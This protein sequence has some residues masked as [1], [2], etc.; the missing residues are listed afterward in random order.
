MNDEEIER[1]LAKWG[2]QLLQ[3]GVRKYGRPGKDPR[4]RR[5]APLDGNSVRKG[6]RAIVRRFPEVMVKVT[7]G[8]R[9]MGA[10]KAHM[11]YI[12]RR[13]ELALE[14]EAGGPV[15]GRDALEC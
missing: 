7:G 4:A 2:S 11:L 8:G 14:D 3:P 10:I 13:G 12:S 6:L 9:G 15:K 5:P 1:T